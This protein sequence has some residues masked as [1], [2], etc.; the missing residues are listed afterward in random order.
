MAK[1]GTAEIEVRIDL[2]RVTALVDALSLMSGLLNRYGH[3]WT[4]DER[5]VLARAADACDRKNL[6]VEVR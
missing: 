6:I 5:T 3:A 1:L 4:D 2:S